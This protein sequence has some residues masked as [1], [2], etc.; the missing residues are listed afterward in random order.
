M[1]VLD[2]YDFNFN[3]AFQLVLNFCS[4]ELSSFFFDIRKDTLYCED[5]KSL[6][7]NSTKTVMSYVFEVLISW[8]TPI[9]PFTTE[10][11]WQCWKLLLTQKLK[12]VVIFY[13]RMTLIQFGK[14]TKLRL[15]GLRFFKLEML[16]YFLQKKNNKEIKSVME[17]N[18][19]FYFKNK[20]YNDIFRIHNFK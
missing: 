11:A 19:E 17:A 8:L 15:N 14:M 20:S 10:E 9:I 3:K 12:K 2:N 4:F 6:L 1:Q 13:N 7:V 5:Q 18:V 16:F